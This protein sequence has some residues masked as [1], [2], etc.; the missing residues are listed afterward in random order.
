MQTVLDFINTYVNPS[1][2][3]AAIGVVISF[4]AQEWR[5]R[6][7]FRRSINLK[8]WETKS[9]KLYTFSEDLELWFYLTTV[10]VNQLITQTPNLDYPPSKSSEIIDLTKKLIRNKTY[11]VRYPK[12][13]ENYQK[14]L[15]VTEWDSEHPLIMDQS[16]IEETRKLIKIVQAEIQKETKKL[17]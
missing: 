10:E 5:E 13:Y 3:G 7:K 17:H 12:I 15:D 1:L 9:E 4:F 11:L 8:A 2:I 16:E 6:V 14:L